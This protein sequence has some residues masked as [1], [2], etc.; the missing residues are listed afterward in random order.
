MSRIV[1][2]ANALKEQFP[3]RAIA[4]AGVDGFIAE[5]EGVSGYRLTMSDW[6]ANLPVADITYRRTRM[7]RL[8]DRLSDWL[9]RLAA[10]IE[11]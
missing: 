7:Q 6:A 4:Q 5:A 1:D 11:S 2:G 3:D 10:R 9:M 8:R